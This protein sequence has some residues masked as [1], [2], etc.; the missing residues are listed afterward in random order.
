MLDIAIMVFL[1][2]AA[3]ELACVIFGPGGAVK[4]LTANQVLAISLMVVAVCF[5]CV[6]IS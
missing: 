5:S 2:A 3:L 1:G 4:I 6:L